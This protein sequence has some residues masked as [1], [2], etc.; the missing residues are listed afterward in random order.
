MCIEYDGLDRM[1]KRRYI[2]NSCEFCDIPRFILI[3]ICK[4]QIWQELAPA[5]PSIFCKRVHDALDTVPGL[6]FWR[7]HCGVVRGEASLTA[8][9]LFTA[10]ERG[11]AFFR[12]IASISTSTCCSVL[13]GYASRWAECIDCS[14]A[15][16]L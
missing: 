14:V 12:M 3:R 6:G 1:S 13:A 4:P 5:I 2:I 8:P 7:L 15:G 11:V 10:P 9:S 16:Q